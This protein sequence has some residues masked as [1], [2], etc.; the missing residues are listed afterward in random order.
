MSNYQEKLKRKAAA[1][2]LKSLCTNDL[3]FDENKRAKSIHRNYLYIPLFDLAHCSKKYDLNTLKEGCYLLQKNNHL[4]IWGDDYDQRAM[5]IQI[6]ETGVEAYQKSLY[7]Y[8]N[9]GLIKKGIA[10]SAAIA[11]TAAIVIGVQ[12]YSSES[13]HN[14]YYHH[15]GNKNAMIESPQR[16]T[17]FLKLH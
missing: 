3:W 15:A 7:N 17:A 5:L 9:S 11:V 14:K 12:K 4:T 13:R 2:I 10:I 8:Y 6:S 1:W 16:S